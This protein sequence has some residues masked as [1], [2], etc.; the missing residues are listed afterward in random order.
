MYTTVRTI[1]AKVLIWNLTVQ[2]IPS[3]VDVEDT[4]QPFEFPSNVQ[5]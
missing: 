3:I 4:D 2:D 1:V 5:G